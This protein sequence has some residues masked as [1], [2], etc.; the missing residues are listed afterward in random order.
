[1][2]K[3]TNKLRKV[4]SGYF[5][6]KHRSNTVA[7]LNTDLPRLI[8]TRSNKHMLGQIVQDGVTLLGAND[9]KISE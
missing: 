5:R 1:M 7:K 8:V 6:R 2:K 9:H 3:L 4:Q